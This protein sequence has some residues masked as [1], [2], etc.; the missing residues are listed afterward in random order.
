MDL[1][2][3]VKIALIL[4]LWWSVSPAGTAPDV[5][6][7]RSTTDLPWPLPD[8]SAPPQRYTIPAECNLNDPVRI[9]RGKFLFHHLNSKK[10]KEKMP[11]K[12]LHEEKI[13]HKKGV[14]Q[15]GN[16]VAC[17]AIEGAKDPGTLG[18]DLSRYKQLFIDTKVRD[19][20]FVYQKI[21]DARIDNPDTRMTINLTTGLFTPSEICDLTA[22]VIAEKY[23]KMKK[24]K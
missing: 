7:N 16:C 20:A 18:P 24:E 9:M 1:P 5:D 4:P 3:A 11:R 13:R 17:H 12:L 23:P 21:A 15:Y 8:R 2:Q 19:A 6:H 10:S 14:K 22:Y